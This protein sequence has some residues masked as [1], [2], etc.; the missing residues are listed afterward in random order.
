MGNLRLIKIFNEKKKMKVIIALALLCAYAHA[1]GLTATKTLFCKTVSSSTDN[2]CTG[3]FN[4]NNTPKALV[5]SGGVNVCTAAFP[6]LVTNCQVYSSSKSSTALAAA[7]DCAACKSGKVAVSTT[8]A[9]GVWTVACT[10]STTAKPKLDSTGNCESGTTSYWNSSGALTTWTAACGFCKSGK[11]PAACVSGT[12][13]T[14]CGASTAIANCNRGGCSG[15][16]VNCVECKSGYALKSDY[17]ACIAKSDKNCL[18]L[19]SNGTSCQS[20]W[21]AY[22][23]SGTVCVKSAKIL[24]AV[25]IA[26]AAFFMN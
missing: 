6:T 16:T 5:A 25:F 21:P 19:N 11:A 7:G 1:A 17:T 14:A 10:D 22:I 23:F 3:C 12:Y 26:A 24:S 18:V 13:N 8:T 20:C 4:W 2:V 15:A 9:G